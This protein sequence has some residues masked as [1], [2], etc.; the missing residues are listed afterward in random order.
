MC[1]CACDGDVSLCCPGVHY[2]HQGD[3]EL[4]E[5]L[6]SAGIKGTYYHTQSTPLFFNIGCTNHIDMIET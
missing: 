4:T 2:V 1:V 5:F 3:R 6:L